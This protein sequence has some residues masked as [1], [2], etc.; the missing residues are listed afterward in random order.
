M[1]HGPQNPPRLHRSDKRLY[2]RR[3][4]RY[5]FAGL[6]PTGDTP[7]SRWGDAC[8]RSFRK[9]RRLDEQ[10][11]HVKRVP[12]SGGCGSQSPFRPASGFEPHA[13][14]RRCIAVAVVHAGHGRNLR[15]HAGPCRTRHPHQ[16]GLSRCA[17]GQT[18][19]RP[20]ATVVKPGAVIARSGHLHAGH[21]G[22]KTVPVTVYNVSQNAPQAKKCTQSKPGDATC[23]R[24]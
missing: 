5:D 3:S 12:G 21:H 7:T 10:V 17:D 14:H 23:A 20:A 18:A 4:R 8:P 11:R 6:R 16:S 13:E 22:E 2:V 9:R 1:R 19:V 15:L 24:K